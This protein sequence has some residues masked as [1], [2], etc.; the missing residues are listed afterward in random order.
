MYKIFEGES[1]QQ[2]L[3][4]MKIDL[5]A[6]A[7]LVEHKV[8]KKG[9]VLGLFSKDVYVVK[10]LPAS[11]LKPS[12]KRHT[13]INH[14][15]MPSTD[16]F[17]FSKNEYIAKLQAAIKEKTKTPPPIHQAKNKFNHVIDDEI[18]PVL[19][20]KKKVPPK[21]NNVYSP[22]KK[23]E[24]ALSITQELNKNGLLNKSV[25]NNLPK[26]VFKPRPDN[27]ENESLTNE[28]QIL[29]NELKSISTTMGVVLEKINQDELKYPGLLTRFYLFLIENEFEEDT[30]D[31]IIKNV[32]NRLDKSNYDNYSLVRYE[33][34]IE[35]KNILQKKEALQ[36]ENNIK[37]FTVIGPTGVGKTTTLAKLGA[38]L[39]L[40]EE[41]NI[42]FLTLDTYRLAAVD[43]LKKYAEVL[44]VPMKVVYMP[45]E[46]NESIMC[47]LKKD[48]ILIDTAGRSPTDE[49]QMKELFDFVS[50]SKF[51]MEIALT[52]SATTKYS[53]L[54]DI[55]EKFSIVN[56]DQLIITKIDETVSLG[57][58]IS[59][60]D[61]FNKPISYIATGQ[62]VPDHF[63]LFSP[64]YFIDLLFNKFEKNSNVELG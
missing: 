20:S 15:L 33:I 60:V 16:N 46:I 63:E 4:K 32:L 62:D 40:E 59:I 29:K 56:F 47:F 48:L 2:A 35:L 28:I 21:R 10:A 50:S 9:G 36:S 64:K 13:P 41:K 61:K 8:I 1:L 38:Y 37:I 23:K 34:E 25:K 58:I 11:D 53:D 52:L 57:Q 14:S 54:V 19:N 55:I 27:K 22:Y 43:Q 3:F 6:D 39:C 12:V 31:K 7:I 51:E 49:I 45:E 17:N 18:I 30:A 24:T 42:S 5:G 26:K 44:N